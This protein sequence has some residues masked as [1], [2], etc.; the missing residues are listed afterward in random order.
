M[1]LNIQLEI[2]RN[3]FNDSINRAAS[4]TGTATRPG[5]ISLING[6]GNSIHGGM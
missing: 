3:G 1:A 6:V 4:W 2:G 5:C